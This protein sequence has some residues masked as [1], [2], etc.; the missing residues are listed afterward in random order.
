VRR[1]P[2]RDQFGL[3]VCVYADPNDEG[4]VQARLVT[5]AGETLQE[6]R[7]R[8]VAYPVATGAVAALVNYA[9]DVAK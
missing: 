8:T 3:R 6:I 7:F 9:Q 5:D 4:A 1:D 2:D